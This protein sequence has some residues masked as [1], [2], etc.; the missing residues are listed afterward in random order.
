MTQDAAFGDHIEDPSSGGAHAT[1]RDETAEDEQS[2]LAKQK[3]LL[4]KDG[5]D[6]GSAR[7]EAPMASAVEPEAAPARSSAAPA[8]RSAEGDAAARRPR[9]TAT[10]AA[11]S[12]STS[13]TRSPRAAAAAGKA[14]DKD[15]LTDFFN[16]L[17]KK[18][19]AKGGAKGT[20]PK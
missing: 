16:S 20:P 10:T 18:D 11:A 2:F 7:E 14:G 17:L 19:G 15:V 12:A 9:A 13:G 1:N 4:G 6:S 5:G 3:Q 8:S